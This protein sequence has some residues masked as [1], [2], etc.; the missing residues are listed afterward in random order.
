MLL[1]VSLVGQVLLVTALA[2]KGSTEPDRPRGEVALGSFSYAPEPADGMPVFGARFQLHLA[3]HEAGDEF[4]RRT[5]AQREFRVRE[6][7]E[8]LLRKAHPGDFRDPALSDLKRQLQDRIN[9][10][11]GMAAVSEIIITGLDLARPGP[12]TRGPSEDG[13]ARSTAAARQPS[14]GVTDGTV[15]DVGL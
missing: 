14:S 2:R 6:G 4:G 12:A 13:G 5:L 9:E 15:Q 7:I 8:E 3:F 1:A 11:L 10:A